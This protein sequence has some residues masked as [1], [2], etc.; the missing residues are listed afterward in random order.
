M[1][2][3]LQKLIESKL[4]VAP[5]IILGIEA[6]FQDFSW[7]GAAGLLE[8]GRN[9]PVTTAHGFRIASMSKTFTGVLCAQ[10]VE[11]GLLELDKPASE[12]LP[13]EIYEL[14]P[15][16]SGHSRD[17]ITVDRLLK[18]RSGLYDFAHVP[19]WRAEIRSDPQRFREPREIAT[20]ALKNG[21][22]VGAP[23]EVYH[24]SDTGFV[25][26]GLLTEEITG[27][28]YWQLCRERILDPLGMNDTWLEGH[29]EMRI[30]M[31]HPY[32]LTDEGEYIDAMQ[33]N[34][35]L[36]WAAGG[37]VST[38]ADIN[39]FLHGAFN[40]ELFDNLSTLDLF[41]HGGFAAPGFHYG[42][43]VGRKVIHGKNLWGHLG[44]W[45]SFMCYCPEER[46]SFTGTQNY[47]A[48]SHNAFIREILEILYPD[49]AIES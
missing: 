20:W 43:G 34:G 26:L 8:R 24:Y 40:N 35:C 23:G 1:E 12:Y 32:S 17:E 37:H 5:G 7:S 28:P 44:H 30:T 33:I 38:V 49:K 25:L 36:D 29:E 47:S 6:R 2:Q 41:T 19:A 18:H 14:I 16:E 22:T 13:A 42:F 27:L 31:S 15:V 39:R 46:L 3:Q 11:Q 4:D 45:G 48:S 9:Q 10:L 21:E